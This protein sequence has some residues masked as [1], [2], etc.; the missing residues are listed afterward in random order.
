[1]RDDIHIAIDVLF[2]VEGTVLVGLE[3]E[4]WWNDRV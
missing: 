3:G 4:G 1:M 2:S